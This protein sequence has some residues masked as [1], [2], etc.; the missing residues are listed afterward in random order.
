MVVQVSAHD[1]DTLSAEIVYSLYG[2]GS[3]YFDID[4]E[5][6][7][8]TVTDNKGLKEGENI[9]MHVKVSF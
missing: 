8:V 5:T 2:E 4:S 7:K 9:L 3:D 6:G 1:Q